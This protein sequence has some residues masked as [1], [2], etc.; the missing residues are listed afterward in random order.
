MMNDKLKELNDLLDT[1]FLDSCGLD[2][3][4]LNSE[5]FKIKSMEQA[6]FFLSKVVEIREQ[7]AEIEALAKEKIRVVTE[8][9]EL[10]KEKEFNSL[11][12]TES[13]FEGLLM[14]FAN[15]KLYD[16]KKKS[17]KLPSGTL[18]FRAQQNEYIYEDDKALIEFLKQ[19]Q[20]EAL[21]TVKTSE[22]LNKS[23][24]KKVIVKDGDEIF[25]DGLKVEGVQIINKEPKFEVK[26][27]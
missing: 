1:A 25:I 26:T 20:K 4:E 22:A 7:K 23:E 14:E 17:L 10:W 27:K 15:S 5:K 16:S 21:V 18:G 19:N 24:I 12:S 2:M 3:E 6:E 9:T 11:N 8:A 13:W